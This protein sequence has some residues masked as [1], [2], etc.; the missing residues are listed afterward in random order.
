M[1]CRIKIPRKALG[2]SL[3]FLTVQ[4]R[5]E[6]IRLQKFLIWIAH[7]L[8]FLFC[9]EPVKKNLWR[10]LTAET[11]SPSYDPVR[12]YL[13]HPS[14]LPSVRTL[15]MTPYGK[16]NVLSKLASFTARVCNRS[17][18]TKTVGEFQIYWEFIALYTKTGKKRLYSNASF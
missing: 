3:R 14:P 4:G 8:L 7:F 11:S 2:S 12:F 16:V 18:L 5:W 6:W 10:T 13:D 17:W 1:T 9:N 15:W